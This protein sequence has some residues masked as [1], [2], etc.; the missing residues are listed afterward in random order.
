MRLGFYLLYY[1]VGKSLFTIIFQPKS[2]T[3]GTCV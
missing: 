3:S 1:G 2:R